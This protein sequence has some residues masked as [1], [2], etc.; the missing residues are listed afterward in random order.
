MQTSRSV[1]VLCLCTA[2]VGG[3][4]DNTSGSAAA[5]VCEEPLVGR[6]ALPE[7]DALHGEKTEWWYWTGHLETAN[8]RYSGFESAFFAVEAEG[9]S[10]QLVN[11]AI[12]DLEDD[13]FHHMASFIE[14]PAAFVPDGVDFDIGGQRVVAGNGHDVLHGEVDGYVLDLTMDAVKRPVFHHGDGY[15]DYT[16]GGFTYYY[17]RERMTATGTLTLPDGNIVEVHGTSWFDHQWGD[18]SGAVDMGWD[19]FALQL[20]DGRAFVEGSLTGAEC[21]TQQLLQDDLEIIANSTWTSPHGGAVYPS[22]WTIRILDETFEITPMMADQEV[23]TI[24]FKY[25]EGAAVVSGA[26]TGR[27][28]VELTGY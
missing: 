4:G 15:T 8:G 24:F 19:W 22:S 6:V 26:A 23:D 12:T 20:D 1:I 21:S 3:C 27:A 16:F 5:S 11:H 7:D 10:G 17:S 9:N 13:S 28:Y 14:M 25:W 18:L 2:L